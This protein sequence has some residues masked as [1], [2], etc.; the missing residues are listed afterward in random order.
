MGGCGQSFNPVRTGH[1]SMKKKAADAVIERSDDTLS[2]PILGGGIG[3]GETEHDAMAFEV[4]THGMVIKFLPIV[5]LQG[6]E[7]KLELSKNMGMK[8]NQTM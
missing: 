3:A 5:S 4:S 7:R 6:K 8:S 1:G 2:L